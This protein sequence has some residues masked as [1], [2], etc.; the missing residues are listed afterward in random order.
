MIV[1]ASAVELSS[2]LEL[3]QFENSSHSERPTK[4]WFRHTGLSGK[5]SGERSGRQ[6]TGETCGGVEHAY[7]VPLICR[8][9][10]SWCT[11]VNQ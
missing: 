6:T 8:E 7:S 9:G 3:L 1:G 5:T 4:R 11:G 10:G 2:W